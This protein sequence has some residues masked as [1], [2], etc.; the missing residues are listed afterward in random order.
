MATSKHIPLP[1]FPD[2]VKAKF[3]RRIL[4][5]ATNEC[6]PFLRARTGLPAQGKPL[7][8]ATFGGKKHWLRASRVAYFLHYGIDPGDK[9]ACHS[10][11]NPPCCNPHHLWPGTNADNS[12]DMVAK[13]RKEKGD[14]HYSRTRPELLARGSKNGM[15]THPERRLY[16]DKNPSRLHPENYRGEA[17][18]GVKLTEEI[19]RELR[20]RFPSGRISKADDS[21][22]AAIYGMVSIRPVIRRQS[23]RHV[24]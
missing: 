1:L 22:I 5:G 9:L 21:R 17:H 23:W 18:W 19:V 13:G 11:D 8:N 3:W 2:S 4:I 15:N 10:C 20:K 16:G 24:T 6:W 14:Q 12:A 7:F